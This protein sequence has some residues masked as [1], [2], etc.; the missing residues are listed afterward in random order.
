M[1]VQI[2]FSSVLVAEWPPFRKELLT[3]LTNVLFVLCPFVIL[4]ISVCFF[5]LSFEGGVWVL[6]P[7][8]CLLLFSVTHMFSLYF[9]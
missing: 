7:S 9:D 5:C 1:L 8:H 3:W 6:V 4:V 2:I